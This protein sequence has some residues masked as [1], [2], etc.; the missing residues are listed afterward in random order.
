MNE[1]I[2]AA[3]FTKGDYAGVY[4]VAYVCPMTCG[5]SVMLILD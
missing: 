3:Y 1:Y 4:C 2:T 5:M